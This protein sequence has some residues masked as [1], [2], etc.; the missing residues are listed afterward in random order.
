MQRDVFNPYI[1]PLLILV[2]LLVLAYFVQYAVKEPRDFVVYHYGAR[3]VFEGTR[4]V[5][6]EASGVGA[7]MIYRY[8]P[9]FL[10][11]FSPLALPPLQLAAV[12]WVIFKLTL[13]VMLVRSLYSR[14]EGTGRLQEWLVPLLLAGPY[15]VQEF[16]SGNAQFF[17][18]VLVAVALIHLEARPGAAALALSLA[19]S[20]K[21][22][23]LFFVPYLAATKRWRTVIWVLLLTVCLTM[24]PV[25]YFGF[26][27]HIQLLGQWFEQEISPQFADSQTWFAISNP[28]PNQALRGVLMRYLTV[29]DYSRLSDSNYRLVHVASL[30]P[31]LVRALCLV[32]VAAGYG[33]LLLLARARAASPGWVEHGVVFCALV[34]FETSSHFSRTVLL[35]PAMLAG[36]IAARGTDVPRW[37]RALIYTALAVSILQPFVPRASSQRLMQVLGLDFLVTCL[38]TIT[39]VWASL[40][41]VLQKNQSSGEVSS[42]LDA[43][44]EEGYREGGPA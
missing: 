13:L 8:P 24:A 2:G 36:Q 44:S 19:A 22:W 10:L 15:V 1:R 14:L 26:A 30:D 31:D 12:I 34:L 4:P 42:Q 17:I 28:P 35:W 32:L 29:I 25:I 37:I 11:V 16:R 33:G 41:S 23:P 43:E 6:G 27:G 39:V 5:Y 9:L 20:L 40:T 18:F 7:P 21:V 3:G 38:L